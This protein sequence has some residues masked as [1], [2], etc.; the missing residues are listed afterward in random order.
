MRISEKQ[1]L[2]DLKISYIYTFYF[3]IAYETLY[4]AYIK[5]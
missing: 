1:Y 4:I 5:M 3:L 2:K